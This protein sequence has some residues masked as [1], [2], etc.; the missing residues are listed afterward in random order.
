M[1]FDEAVFHAD[2]E[3]IV[4]S[5]LNS[6]DIAKSYDSD[7]RELLDSHAPLI[8]RTVNSR[9]SAPWMSLEIKQ[10]KAERRRAERKWVT[11][12]LTIHR[13]IFNQCKSKVKAFIASGKKQ[14]YS[15]KIAESVSSKT[16]F[17]IANA[18]SAKGRNTNLPSLFPINE[19]P[20][21]FGVFFQ[22]KIGKIR[23]SLDS[24]KTN[25]SP[26]HEPFHGETFDNF[27]LVSE[28]DIRSLI[29]S[30]SPKSCGLDPIPTSLLVK[31]FDSLCTVITKII[32][33]SLASGTVPESFKHAI[34]KPLLKK[35]KPLS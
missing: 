16:L 10:A 28:Q 25:L 12:K 1:K 14:Y 21:K 5:I 19:L 3:N 8:K 20:D 22:S 31:H 18:M 7:L 15:S 24:L 6:N 13:D 2:L 4:P 23:S 9:S 34:I 29:T 11:S 17:S 27:H 26:E 35:T 32:N 33:N 30:S